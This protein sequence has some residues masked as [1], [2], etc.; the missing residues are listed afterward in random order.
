MVTSVTSLGRNG[1]HDW[2]LQR[3]T[4]V[5]MAVYFIFVAGW[6]ICQGGVDY[7]AWKAFMGSACMQIANTLVFFSIAIHAWAGLWIVTTDYITRMQFGD[8]A[9]RVRLLIQ[10]VIAG[11]TLVYVLW[12]L[13]MI[14][15][16]A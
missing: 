4:A 9:T 12:G 13:L 7:L 14:W 5:L 6:L 1:L 11:L 10:L 15:G 3:V 16:G 2:L 8:A